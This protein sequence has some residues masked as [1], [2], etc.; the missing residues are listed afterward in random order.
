MLARRSVAKVAVMAA[1]VLGSSMSYASA[2]SSPANP[3]VTTLKVATTSAY[4]V[5]ATFDAYEYGVTFVDQILTIDWGDG[6]QSS[7]TYVNQLLGSEHTYPALGTFTA[8]ATISDGQGQ[9]AVTTALAV[10]GARYTAYGPARLLD[11]R[12]GIGAPAA[13]VSPHGTVAVRATGTPAIPAS[14]TAVAVNLTVTD[15]SDSGWIAATNITASAPTTSNLNYTAG[16]TVANMA[17]VP[18]DPSNGEVYLYNGSSTASVDLVVDIDGYFTPDAAKSGYTPLSPSRL[19]DTR[20]GV[21]AIRGQ[22]PGHGAVTLTISGADGGLLPQSGISAVELNLTATN[23]AGG[24]WI[25]AVPDTPSAPTPTTSNLNYN[26]G[27]TIANAVIVPVGA[28]GRIRL[29]NGSSTAVDLI[30]DVEGYLS[31]AGLSSLVT[32]TPSRVYDSRDACFPQE[33]FCTSIPLPARYLQWFNF[34]GITAALLNVTA[35]QTTSSGYLSV[36]P[37]QNA[38]RTYGGENPVPD[39]TTPTTSTLN[40]T[41]GQTVPNFAIVPPAGPDAMVDVHNESGGDI[42]FVVDSFGAFMT[43]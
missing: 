12:K 39:V 35:T 30:A 20:K 13:K 2:A 7:S 43:K 31:A 36:T 4:S 42:A 9:T 25:A 23:P 15:A 24:G 34:A 32:A 22:I 18:V 29:Y 17:I 41:A 19:L 38:Q 11:T 3:L 10:T 40:F 37:D 8:T 28:D 14:A 27:Q 1:A 16:Q 33:G 5:R 21:G 6:T 26:R